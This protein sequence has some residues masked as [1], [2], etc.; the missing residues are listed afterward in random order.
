MKRFIKPIYAHCD[1]PCGHYETDTL[2]NSAQTCHKLV[3]KLLDLSASKLKT[4]E[5]KHQFI[6]LTTIK[7]DHAQIC[8]NQIYI[9]WS[10][11][12]KATH[13]KEYPNLS[14]QLY[15]L[16]QMT[17]SVKQTIDL[18]AT[19]LLIEEINSLDE[20]FQATQAT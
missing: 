17:S 3:K 18:K 13:Y 19:T 7:E 5:D 20:I 10:D 2:K 12:F 1:G 14:L 4:I 9:L 11:Y 15:Q 6:R 16:A 8:K